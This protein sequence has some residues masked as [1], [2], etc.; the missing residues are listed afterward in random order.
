MSN[1]LCVK[2][3][4]E[5]PAGA[6]FCPEC[7][8]PV[9]ENKIVNEPNINREKNPSVG[10]SF[11]AIQ[12]SKLFGMFSRFI[13]LF[14]ESFF[15]RRPL[16][17]LYIFFACMN[18]LAP[19]YILFVL[20]N[21]GL[22]NSIGF[23]AF[24]LWLIVAFAG[25]M[26]FQLWWNRREKISGYYKA[27]DDFYAIPLFSHL[28]QTIGEWFGLTITIIGTSASIIMW[29]FSSSDRMRAF[30]MPLP[31]D[32]VGIAGVIIFPVVGFSILLFTKV[33]AELYRA[34]AA[35]ANNTKAALRN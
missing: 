28:I 11:K 25:W 32:T 22:L 29:I 6:T 16:L 18:I 20:I 7:G 9:E 34:L 27:G 23:S 10:D 13:D 24:V 26:G 4:Y 12:Q 8:H 30:P 31:L 1:K 17:W 14:D 5:I 2:C 33:L 3:G 35:I 21:S 15:L 19:V